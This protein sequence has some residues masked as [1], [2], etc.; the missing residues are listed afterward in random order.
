MSDRKFL[1]KKSLGQHFLTS[2][3]VPRWMCDA[4]D[5]Q[6]G[7]IVFEIGPGSGV[8]TKEILARGATVIALEA[9]ERAIAVLTDTFTETLTTGQLRMHHGD[10]RKLDFA[11]LGLQN[12]QFKAVSNIPYYLSGQ[13]FRQLLDSTCQPT[14]LVFL[15]QKEVAERIARD[16]KESL[17]SLS[18]KVFGDPTYIKTV[19][20]GH[21]TPKPDVDSAIVA[22]HSISTDRFS[23]LS[24]ELFFDVIHLGFAQKRKQ[25][26]GNLAKFLER[27]VLINIFS[28]VGLAPDVRAEDVPLEVWLEL[29][30]QIAIHTNSTD[31]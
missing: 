28:T 1:H 30:E 7:D 21:F 15:V 24:R 10:A 22:V 9:D 14:D 8:L 11:T 16:E 3:V 17:L 6:E 31:T 12:G 27:E 13:L 29:V 4:A 19:S 23:G 20:A 5:I 2:P 25:L 26:L 18:V